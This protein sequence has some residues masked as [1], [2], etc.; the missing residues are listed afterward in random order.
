MRVLVVED[1]QSVRETLGI[2]LQ[3]YQHQADLAEDEDSALAVLN[4]SVKDP[5]AWPDVLLL[6]LKLQKGTGEEVYRSIQSHFGRVPPTVVISAAQEGAYRASQLPNVKFL[7]KPYTVEELL[8]V[9]ESRV[10]ESAPS[11][12][13][14]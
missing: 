14:A 6:D 13:T 10:S 2:V 11:S 8:A 9:L 12:K 3:A 5:A 1:D 7:A 4:R